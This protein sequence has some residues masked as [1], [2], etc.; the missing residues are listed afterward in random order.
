MDEQREAVRAMQNYI[1]EHIRDEIT[2]ED[3]AGAAAFSTWYAR[4]LFIMSV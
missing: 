3:L 1:C 2:I 4:K